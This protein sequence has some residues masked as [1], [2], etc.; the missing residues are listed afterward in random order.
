M[1]VAPSAAQAASAPVSITEASWTP[2]L[3]TAKAASEDNL[4]G[5]VKGPPPP[6][7]QRVACLLPED[8]AGVL[9]AIRRERELDAV[10]FPKTEVVL[11]KADPDPV[12]EADVDEGMRLRILQTKEL[13]PP[14]PRLDPEGFAAFYGNRQTC[15]PFP[16]PQQLDELRFRAEGTYGR[17]TLDV[18]LRGVAG[19]EWSPF[20]DMLVAKMRPLWS[21]EVFVERV[22]SHESDGTASRTLC[23]WTGRRLVLSWLP[24]ALDD[25]EEELRKLREAAGAALAGTGT[26]IASVAVAEREAAEREADDREAERLP[27]YD[28]DTAESRERGARIAAAFDAEMAA[29]LGDNKSQME[30]IM[31]RA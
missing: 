29:T 13:V 23:S 16:A 19:F 27:K 22:A 26:P 11:D 28:W 17:C 10:D 12:S 6:S 15:V 4:R 2:D 25:L 8:L 30:A 5:L 3:P 9:E 24:W 21:H 18:A 1:L 20:A 14:D 7:P 31:E